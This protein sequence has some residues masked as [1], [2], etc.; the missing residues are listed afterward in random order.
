VNRLLLVGGVVVGA[1]LGGLATRLTVIGGILFGAAVGLVGAV[2]IGLVQRRR[3]DAIAGAVSDWVDDPQADRRPIPAFRGPDWHRLGRTVNTLGV[4]YRRLRALAAREPTAHREFV[5]SLTPP[6]LLFAADGTLS[7]SN[8]AAY[9]LFQIPRTGPSSPIQVL[10]NAVLAAAVTETLADHAA[11]QVTAEVAD[12]YVM[13]SV[14]SL[15]DGVLVIATDRTEERRVDEVRRNFVVNASHELKTPVTS[16]QTLVEA[17]AVAS[18]QQSDRV[19]ALDR[20]TWR[21][22]RT[23]RESRP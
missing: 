11:R 18:G 17:L 12:R 23:A 2:A 1:M 9:E 6:A 15:G 3:L 13:V 7:G 8:A 14:S 16:I 4:D 20:T 21:R 19:P 22:G 5:A 10:G